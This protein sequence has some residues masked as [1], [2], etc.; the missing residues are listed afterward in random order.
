VARLRGSTPRCGN[1]TFGASNASSAVSILQQ[2]LHLVQLFEFVDWSVRMR[3]HFAERLQTFGFHVTISGQLSVI[4]VVPAGWHANNS[5]NPA[6]RR[7]Q[8][9]RWRPPER[10]NR[11]DQHFAPGA[12]TRR[13]NFLGLLQ[14]LGMYIWY[15]AA[16]RRL[17]PA[18]TLS[19]DGEA[20]EYI[21]RL[22]AR[23]VPSSPSE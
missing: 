23:A 17:R 16:C 10:V 8:S 7:R 20:S 9:L 1:S 11:P 3:F 22:A 6:S 2:Q 4:D 15:Q 5:V 18:S 21:A 13:T 14:V 12:S 19:R